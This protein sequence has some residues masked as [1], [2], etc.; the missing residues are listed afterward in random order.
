MTSVSRRARRSNTEKTNAIQEQNRREEKQ[1][2]APN[3]MGSKKIIINN[4]PIIERAITDPGQQYLSVPTVP[5]R[6]LTIE[7]SRSK[8]FMKLH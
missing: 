6:A 5:V 4:Y 2:N 7:A 1:H 8:K 3:K